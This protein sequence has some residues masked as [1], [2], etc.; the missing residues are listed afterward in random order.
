[1]ACQKVCK[2]GRDDIIVK[3]NL[4]SPIPTSFYIAVTNQCQNDAGMWLCKFTFTIISS[5]P[6]L[7][8]FW[9]AIPTSFYIFNVFKSCTAFAYKYCIYCASAPS[10][11]R[12]STDSLIRNTQVPNIWSYI[13]IHIYIYIYICIDN[14]PFSPQVW[15]SLRSPQSK[16][17]A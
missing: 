5:L 10:L 15:S 4:Q 2:Q 7:H 8:T 17:V 6:C 13:Y 12:E 11:H 9:H 1:M 16:L 3:V 14:F